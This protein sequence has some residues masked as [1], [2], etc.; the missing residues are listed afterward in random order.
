MPDAL[1]PAREDMQE[2]APNELDGLEGHHTLAVPMGVVFPAKGHPSVL[3]PDDDSR[4]P[5]D[6]YSARGTLTPSAARQRAA[7]HTPPTTGGQALEELLPRLGI[8]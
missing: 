3:Q 2:E 7:W 6:G 5:R 1:E 4:L 8:G